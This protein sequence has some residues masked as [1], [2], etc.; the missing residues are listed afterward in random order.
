MNFEPKLINCEAQ[1]RLMRYRRVTQFLNIIASTYQTVHFSIGL[2]LLEPSF[3]H[4]QARANFSLL[5]KGPITRNLSGAC[6]SS[7]LIIW[8]EEHHG[9]A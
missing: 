7:D 5:D 6:A 2:I 1:S 9:N 3:G 4:A 8:L